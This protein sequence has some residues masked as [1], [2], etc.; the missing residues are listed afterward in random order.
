MDDLLS[1]YVQGYEQLS[2]KIQTYF[3]ETLR[4]WFDCGLLSLSLSAG[5]QMK[6][7]VLSTGAASRPAVALFDEAE[8]ANNAE[9]FRKFGP[10]MIVPNKNDGSFEVMISAITSHE[11]S[12]LLYELLNEPFRARI[13]RLYEERIATCKRHSEGGAELLTSGAVY[14]RRFISGYAAVT[15]LEYWAECI[16][17][18]SINE[19]QG[20]LRRIDQAMFDSIQELV[21][22]PENHLQPEWA[23]QIAALR[24]KRSDN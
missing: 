3:K 23:E 16:A 19:T 22:A 6:I 11:F 8:L 17:A 4:L 18:F 24:E 7:T 12:H 21:H 15:E 2:G 5:Q 9:N 10:M 13:P 14:T 20:E 1:Q